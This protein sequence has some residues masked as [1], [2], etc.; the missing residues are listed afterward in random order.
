MNLAKQLRDNADV[1]GAGGAIPPRAVAGALREAA[2]A[3]EEAVPLV[4]GYAEN[5]ELGFLRRRKARAWLAKVS[6]V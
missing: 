3:I 5:P 2:E 4:M 1:L 6:D